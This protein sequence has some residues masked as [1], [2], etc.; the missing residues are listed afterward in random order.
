MQ[1]P[2]AIRE[3]E[4]PMALFFPTIAV[5]FHRRP[6]AVVIPAAFKARCNRVQ[7]H[8]AARLQ[9]SDGRSDIRRPIC[10]ALL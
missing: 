2:V 5:A 6:R 10:R 7:R 9:G 1:W 3:T 4:E 8:S